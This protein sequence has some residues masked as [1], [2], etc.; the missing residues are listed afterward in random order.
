MATFVGD[1]SGVTVYEGQE[2][3]RV[4]AWGDNSARVRSTLGPSTSDLDPRVTRL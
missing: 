4:E 3:L 1:K 2:V